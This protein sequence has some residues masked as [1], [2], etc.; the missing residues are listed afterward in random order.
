MVNGATG[1]ELWVLRP[2]WC[3]AFS[4]YPTSHLSVCRMI[5]PYGVSHGE[6][7]VVG[8]ASYTALL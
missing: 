1:I 8:A 5:A 6:A 7:S 3:S 2:L 4:L